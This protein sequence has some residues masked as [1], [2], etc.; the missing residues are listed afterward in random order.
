MIQSVAQNPIQEHLRAFPA[1][2]RLGKYFLTDGNNRVR[3]MI[4]GGHDYL[5]IAELTKEEFDKVKYSDNKHDIMVYY[6]KP[7]RTIKRP[8]DRGKYGLDY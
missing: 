3:G 4:L 7:S 2:W 1:Y 5:P 8:R 6:P